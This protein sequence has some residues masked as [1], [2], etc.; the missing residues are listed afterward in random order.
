MRVECD[1]V[2]K[3][4]RLRRLHLHCQL[5][6]VHASWRSGGDDFQAAVILSSPSLDFSLVLGPNICYHG[7]HYYS[8]GIQCRWVDHYAHCSCALGGVSLPPHSN[9]EFIL[10]SSTLLFLPLSARTIPLIEILLSF[11]NAVCSPRGAVIRGLIRHHIS[12][13]T[14]LAARL[15][16]RP[17]V[18]SAIPPLADK[19]TGTPSWHNFQRCVKSSFEN[20]IALS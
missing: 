6:G 5:L 19:G 18:R 4:E 1:K 20:I 2:R 3:S 7:E 12:T 16:E 10:T 17:F 14:T 9:S 8:R 13:H 15:Y 11:I